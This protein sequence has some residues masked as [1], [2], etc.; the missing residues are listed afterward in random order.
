MNVFKSK[1]YYNSF[2]HI[3]TKEN[4]VFNPLHHNMKPVIWIFHIASCYIM[5]QKHIVCCHDLPTSRNLQLTTKKK[6]KEPQTLMQHFAI[7]FILRIVTWLSNCFCCNWIFTVTLWET[8][9]SNTTHTILFQKNLLLKSGYIFEDYSSLSPVTAE[10]DVMM[11]RISFYYNT[12][13][14]VNKGR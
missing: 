5:N 1:W 9:Y 14:N 4:Y 2:F 13:F 10:L 11:V 12:S 7:I 6:D 8:I 3:I